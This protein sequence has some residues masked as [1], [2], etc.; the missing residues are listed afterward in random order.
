MLGVCVSW[1][2]VRDLWVWPGCMVRGDW[3]G[4][5]FVFGKVCGVEV[6]WCVGWEV[7]FS[8]ASEAWYIVFCCGV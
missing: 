3:I 1:A 7:F 8:L 2:L 4:L 6:V 5:Y